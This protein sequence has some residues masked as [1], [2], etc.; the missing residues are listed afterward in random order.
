MLDSSTVIRLLR[1]RRHEAIAQKVASLTRGDAVICTVVRHELMFGA[2]RD[3][4]PEQALR[5][6]TEFLAD[7][8]C[9]PLDAN[10][11][12]LAARF[13]ITLAAA[14]TPI[15][16]YDLLIAAISAASG[17]T[18]VTCNA[19]EFRRVPGLPVEDWEAPQ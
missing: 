9:L 8:P 6:L 3:R 7:F 4:E 11:A 2:L 15:G 19:R 12:D 1:R 17:L 16:P 10:S 5:H 18:V 13:R 14:G